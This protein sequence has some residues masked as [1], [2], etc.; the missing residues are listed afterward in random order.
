MKKPATVVSLL[1]ITLAAFVAGRYSSGAHD[2]DRPVRKRILYYVDPMHPAFR[3]DHPGVAPD[4]GMKLEPVYADENPNSNPPLQA[5]AVSITAEKQRLIGVRVQAVKRNSGSRVIHTTGRVEADGNRLFRLMAATEGWVQS[6]QDNPAGT[7]VKKNELL[8]SFYSREFRNAEQA[9][10]GALASVERV[11]ATHTQDELNLA[12]DSILVTSEEQLR[13][14]GMGEPQI[15]QLAKTREITRDIALVSP[16]DGIVLARNISP[17]ERFEAHSELYRIADLSKIWILADLYGDE[18]KTLR[19]N[20]QITVRVR[21]LSETL[22]A[23]VSLN[24]PLFDPESRTLKLRLEADNPGLVLRPDMFVDLEF[25]SKVPSGL[26]VPQEAVL[27]SGLQKIVYV[28]TSE[29]VFVP[30]PVEIGTAYGDSVIVIHG[31]SEGEQV[32]TSGNFLIDSES[33]MRSA[34]LNVG[35][36]D[37]H[38]PRGSDQSDHKLAMRGPVCGMPLSPDSAQSTGRLE[39]HKGKS[40]G[41]CSEKNQKNLR[42]S[43][44][45]NAGVTAESSAGSPRES[46][47]HDD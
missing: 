8:A 26:S 1:I 36:S 42:E 9:Y 38:A 17:Q 2:S 13:A 35:G 44:G 18:A 46:E 6:L 16:V 27:D 4:C 43:P 31:L 34:G 32:V 10:L 23:K 40:L 7:M 37:Y 29:G 19:P 24:P 39:T 12:N 28:E 41:F 14:L 5:G 25:E 45:G 33:R 21:E 11:R 30:R 20:S 3:S 15:Q 47:R 22:H